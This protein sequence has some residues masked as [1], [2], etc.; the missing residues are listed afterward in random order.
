MMQTPPS[1]QGMSPS[2]TKCHGTIGSCNDDAAEMA[3]TLS[4]LPFVV[5]QSARY[6]VRNDRCRASATGRKLR[7]WIGLAPKS[8][9]AALCALV[10]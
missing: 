9:K 4:T 5:T 1:L 10:G 2:D 8:C 7:L 6:Y 3:H